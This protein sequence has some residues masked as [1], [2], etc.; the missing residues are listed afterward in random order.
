MSL[1]KRTQYFRFPLHVLGTIRILR[2]MQTQTVGRAPR[3]PVRQATR[4][5]LIAGMVRVGLDPREATRWCDRW[6]AEQTRQGM[7]PE[8]D[9]Y[10]DAAAGWIDAHRGSTT[11]IR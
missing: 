10:W 6:E 5:S 11:P 7:A 4:A 3:K 9:Y 1:R 8:G 2:A